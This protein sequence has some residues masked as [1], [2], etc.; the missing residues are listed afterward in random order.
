MPVKCR[1]VKRLPNA[2]RTAQ[3]VLPRQP[4]PVYVS[5]PARK[6]RT[7]DGCD[8]PDMRKRR[9]LLLLFQPR[10]E[11]GSGGRMGVLGVCGLRLVVPGSDA[12]GAAA[13]VVLRGLLGPR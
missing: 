6:A 9:G 8:L 5:P 2:H 11:K 13:A 1:A 4:G 12:D 7:S 3:R 10:P